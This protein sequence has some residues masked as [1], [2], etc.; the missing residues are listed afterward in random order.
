MHTSI[1]GRIMKLL[2]PAVF[3][4]LLTA[5]KLYAQETHREIDW[6]AGGT[7]GAYFLAQPGELVIEVEKRDR[8][9]SGRVTELRAILAGPDRE[10]LQDLSI[11][12][13][14]QSRGSGL[15]PP[16]R[17][18]LRTQVPR[19]GVYVLNITVSNDR[20]GEDVYWAFWTN[21]PHYLVETSRGHRD[22]RHE[23]PIVIH[24]PDRPGDICFWPRQDAFAMEIAFPAGSGAVTV[25]DANDAVV[26]E[27]A[28]E[29]GKISHDFPADVHRDARP[30]RLHFASADAVADIDGVTRWETGDL[31]V[32]MA[33]WTPHRQSWFPFVENRWLLTPYRRT[34]YNLPGT[35]GETVLQVH[36]NRPEAQV[37]SLSVEFPGDPWDIRL[38]TA[39]V[40][41]PPRSVVETQLH[42]TAPAEGEQRTCHV[43]A[44]PA[45]DSGFSTFSTLVVRGG[46]PPAKSPLTMPIVLQPYEHENEQFGYLPEY[47][48]E[49]QVYFDLENRPYVRTSTGVAR[50]RDGRWVH[51][52][53]AAA[54][55]RR[56]PEFPVTEYRLSSTKLA[57]DRD[58]DLYLVST[59]GP[60]AL[61]LHSQDGGESFTAY[62]IPGRE[63]LPHSFDIE[64]FTGHNLPD[65]PPPILRYTRIPQEHDPK[66]FWRTISEM[67][68]FLP[69]KTDHGIEMGEPIFI[70]DMTLGLSQ[71]SGIPNCVVSRDDRVHV[72]WGEAT[73]P[74][75]EVPGVPAYVATYTRDGE[76]LGEPVLVGYG[77]PPNDVHNSPCLTIDSRGY[78]HVLA[79]TH[80]RPFQYAR[81]LQPDSAHG[82]FTPAV[83]SGESISQTYIGLTCGADDTLHLVS[84][85]WRSGAP[86]PQSSHGTL[87]YQRKRPDQ[88]WEAP[89][90]LVVA[91]FSEYSIFYHRLTTDR[92]G[93]LFLSYDYWSTYWF[94]RNDHRG[95]RR[96]LLMSPDGGESWRLW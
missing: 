89:R 47:P 81:S 33:C 21:C 92:Q 60:K 66:L 15:G 91:P 54:V 67:E 57:F 38:E 93:Q 37:V 61:L 23:E 31:Y 45:D 11:P 72:V 80:G 8:N 27:L 39:Q 70:S 78:L 6:A 53:L 13:A 9:Q 85:V 76:R 30:W 63:D 3:M 52:A 44:T 73:D 16:Q 49:N 40:T 96:A 79:G 2:V 74:A 19:T 25:Y 10:V 42:F 64:V 83:A 90:P 94:Y 7:G 48:V 14:G 77:A 43:R 82:G 22:R 75:E 28:A 56:V 86:F 58:N 34:V 24:M 69:R 46:A 26:A 29:D 71:H 59:A 87:G 36:N 18:V 50:Q 17:A 95:G 32:N 55:T 68:M 51:S 88:P 84:R 12:F 35:G 65:G 20:Y 62:E 1:K 4:T 41:V 5:A